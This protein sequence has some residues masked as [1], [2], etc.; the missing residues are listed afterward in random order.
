MRVNINLHN[1]IIKFYFQNDILW[2]AAALFLSYALVGS[3]HG[4][5]EHWKNKAKE[6]GVTWERRYHNKL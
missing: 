2:R 3:G 5:R 6:L 1:R 4:Q